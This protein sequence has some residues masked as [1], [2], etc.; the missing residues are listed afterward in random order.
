ME[1]CSVAIRLVSGDS[2]TRSIPFSDT[3]TPVWHS[4]APGWLFRITDPSVLVSPA[5]HYD[6]RSF[7]FDRL[8]R[9][10][11]MLRLWPRGTREKLN[12]CLISSC[13]READSLS[14]RK[15]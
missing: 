4:Q 10:Q 6:G 8:L 2:Q 15:S 11:T 1:S 13:V 14:R 7:I 5:G 3:K 9:S 12:V